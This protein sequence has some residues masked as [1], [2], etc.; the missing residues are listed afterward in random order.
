MSILAFCKKISVVRGG[1]GLR[2]PICK[3][4]VFP[5][6][7]TH[8]CRLYAHEF[9]EIMPERC[10]VYGCNNTASTTKGISLYRIPYFD[11]TR[12]EAKSRRKKWA[13]FI[14]RKRDKWQPSASSVVCSQHFTEDCFEY[15]SDTV[16][17]YK[18]PKL[19]RDEI[20][21][22][23][24]PSLLP[25]AT[26]LASE[27]TLRKQQREKVCQHYILS[28]VFYTNFPCFIRPDFKLF[29]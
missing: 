20:G 12:P 13:S 11:D 25:K 2:N 18:V 16:E 3:H 23:A 8:C 27:R 5:N 24:V 29:Y 10:V 14:Q 21:I 6:K 1:L 28:H 9:F 19:T 22:T 4:A 7:Y 17:K 15:G 26:S